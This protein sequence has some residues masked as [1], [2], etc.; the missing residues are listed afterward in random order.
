MSMYV[1]ELDR[2][3]S[4]FV[5]M[6]FPYTMRFALFD[7]HLS[8]YATLSV[9]DTVRHDSALCSSCL[10]R[11]ADNGIV[12]VMDTIKRRLDPTSI[13]SNSD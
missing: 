13:T 11:S 2:L 4:V 7:S 8:S 3:L 9:L 6:T 1:L 12:S 5:F 10:Q